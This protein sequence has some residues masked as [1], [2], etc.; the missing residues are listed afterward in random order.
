MMGA[1]RPSPKDGCA[2]QPFDLVQIF[3]QAL[4]DYLLLSE[5]LVDHQADFFAARLRPPPPVALLGWFG[6]RSVFLSARG[7]VR[8]VAPRESG[9]SAAPG[10]TPRGSRSPRPVQRRARSYP[11][12]AR[13]RPPSAGEAPACGRQRGSEDLRGSPGSAGVRSRPSTPAQFAGKPHRAA[14][15]LHIALDDIHPHAAPGEIADFFAGGKPRGEDQH[16][17]LIFAEVGLLL[18]QSSLHGFGAYPAGVNPSTIIG[19]LD[20]DPSRTMKGAHMDQT[21]G[22]LVG[23]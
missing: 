14:E 10:S 11:C 6:A 8:P 21:L 2:H 13:L 1:T 23:R 16:S 15:L 22:G 9:T 7:R 17:D 5:E 12:W 20:D 19:Y 3:L 18:D 4:D